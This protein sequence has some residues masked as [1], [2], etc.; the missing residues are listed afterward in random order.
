MRRLLHERF[1]PDSEILLQVAVPGPFPD[2][3]TY[4][5]TAEA[6]ADL[7]GRR[8][9]VPLRSRQVVGII[10]GFVADSHID[11]S[12]L[13]AVTS[14]IDM[15]PIIHEQLKDLILFMRNYYHVSLGDAYYTALPGLICAGKALESKRAVKKQIQQFEEEKVLLTAEQQAVFD[16]ITATG[17]E[18]FAV[19]LLEG[20]TG[21]GKTE[22]YL[23]CIEAVLQQGSSAL[24]LIPE[25][26]LTPQTLN[27]FQ[28]RLH[29]AVYVYHSGLTEAQRRDCWVKVMRGEI[30]VVIG[31]RSAVFLPFT[32]LSLIIIDEEHDVSY[33]QQTGV[34]YSAKSIALMRAKAENFPVILGS[35]TPSAE[36]YYFAGKGIYQHHH[37]KSRARTAKK[38]ITYIIDMRQFKNESGFSKPFLE[39]MEKHLQAGQQVLVFLNRRGFAP[40]LLCGTCG[41]RVKCPSCE[42]SYT[43]HQSPA[44]LLCHHC[45]RMTKI[46]TKCKSCQS[47]L[48][49][50]GH[51][52]QQL[53][54]FLAEKFKGYALLRLDQDATR[55]QGELEAGL[56]KIKNR[57]ADII[58][59]TQ[60]LAKGHDFPEI[61]WVGVVD[62]DYG[63]FAPDFRG[64]ERMG[65]LLT[66]VSGRAG[67]G[68]KQGEVVIQTHVPQHPLLQCLLKEGYPAFLNQL[69]EERQLAHWPPFRHLA[70]LR[71]EA[72]NQNV[73]MQFLNEAKAYILQQGQQVA[74]LGPIP[75]FLK[76][77]NNYYR[78]QIIL[79]SE[80][81]T[82]LHQALSLLEHLK[83]ERN[84]V[85]FYLDVDPVEVG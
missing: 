30:K 10:S 71:A 60:M 42:M 75:A 51:G 12:R 59:G 70:L 35:A 72:K 8:A 47:E 27:R 36:S 31:T 48:R 81:R 9:W 46:P 79:E 7:I 56:E 64:I 69:L 65:Q 39:A 84:Q 18:A 34:P 23:K 44:M 20:V 74:V 63:F 4:V 83:S 50:L 25:I 82:K 58:I 61:T 1:L 73:M 68:E 49:T 29:H 19:H 16:T 5:Y 37:L 45:G 54:T 3:L 14:L 55:R 21:S 80:N 66:Q 26:G 77:K 43:L 85:R 13:K 28:K 53:E 52:T 24:V 62:L 11:R 67:R 17:Y 2:G 33:K 57:Q 38:N 40:I 22:V 41:E 76:K 78:A 15:A 6:A 32:D